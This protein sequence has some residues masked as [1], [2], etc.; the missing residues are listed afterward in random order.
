MLVWPD[1]SWD[2]EAWY[3]ADMQET[4]NSHEYQ[5]KKGRPGN[6]YEGVDQDPAHPGLGEA[7]GKEWSDANSSENPGDVAG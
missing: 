3:Y 6:E 4:T 1:K 2:T 7:L 5:M